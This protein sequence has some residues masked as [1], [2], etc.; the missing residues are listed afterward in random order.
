MLAI[1]VVGVAKRE[2]IGG[3]GGAETPREG[4]IS[5]KSFRTPPSIAFVNSL[6]NSNSRT[7]LVGRLAVL[8]AVP[9]LFMTM[10]AQCS[11]PGGSPD[12]FPQ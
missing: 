3:S 9:S 7:P 10:G 5:K 2:N 11:L 8:V 12:P 6:R 4:G 1:S